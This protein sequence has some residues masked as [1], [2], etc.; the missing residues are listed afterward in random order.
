MPMIFN[1]NCNITVFFNFLQLEKYKT[2]GFTLEGGYY[3]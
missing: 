1:A 2:C 3:N